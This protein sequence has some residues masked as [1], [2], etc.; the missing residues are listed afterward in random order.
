MNDQA[1]GQTSEHD[2]DDNYLELKMISPGQIADLCILSQEEQAAK[3][4]DGG[5][6]P[7]EAGI[8]PYSLP[9]MAKRAPMEPG[10]LDIRVHSLYEKLKKIQQ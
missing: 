8:N 9:I 4:E 3:N 10:R 7:Y 5:F 1:A 6:E 2:D